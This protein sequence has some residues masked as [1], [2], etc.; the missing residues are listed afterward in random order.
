VPLD[1]CSIRSMPSWGIFLPPLA[2]MPT[3]W[4]TDATH[5]FKPSTPESPFYAMASPL[6]SGECSVSLVFFDAVLETM[7]WLEPGGGT[8][9]PTDAGWAEAPTSSSERPMGERMSA[10][11]ASLLATEL[12]HIFAEI[13]SDTLAHAQVGRRT[14]GV[15][16][17]V[18]YASADGRV[19]L[20][21]DAAHAMPPSLGEGANCALES[22]V[23]LLAALP[24]ADD[25]PPSINELSDAFTDYGHTRPAEVRPVQMRST[26][27]SQG[28]KGI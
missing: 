24:A 12:P 11:L 28:K 1:A 2:S 20:I 6:P 21:G 26:A 18:D 17:A 7:P 19:A 8:S 22:A 16:L 15:D 10:G 9:A 4:R 25:R 23:S 13:D 14:S 3:G 5:V 27:A